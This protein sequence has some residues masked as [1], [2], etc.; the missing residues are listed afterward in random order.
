MPSTGS[1]KCLRRTAGRREEKV[2]ALITRG[3]PRKARELLLKL[4]CPWIP[5]TKTRSFLLL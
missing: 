4:Y 3:R 2:L 5:R 1:M